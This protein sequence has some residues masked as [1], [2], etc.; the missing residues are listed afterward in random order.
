MIIS[1]RAREILFP[2]QPDSPWK[3]DRPIFDR[4]PLVYQDKDISTGEGLVYIGGPNVKR[5]G[6][7]SLQV[8]VPPIDD[9]TKILI[10]DGVSSWAEGGIQS[11][12][13][14]VDL[15]ALDIDDGQWM[16]GL[17]RVISTET[18]LAAVAPA[19][20]PLSSGGWEDQRFC[21]LA[22]F[23]T[24]FFTVRNLR[25]IR[26]TTDKIDNNVADWITQQPDELV[27]KYQYG[28]K[29]FADEYLNPLTAWKRVDAIDP[30][31]IQIDITNQGIT[32]KADIAPVIQNIYK[33]G[34]SITLEVKAVTKEGYTTDIPYTLAELEDLLSVS[35]EFLAD[36]SFAW[37]WDFDP[38]N[39]TNFQYLPNGETLTLVF[40][41]SILESNDEFWN[42]GRED[43]LLDYIAEQLGWTGDEA[44][45]GFNM[46]P[47]E[48]RRVLLGSFGVHSKDKDYSEWPSPFNESEVPEL[49][50]P[51][52]FV[53]YKDG[54]LGILHDETP[55][56]SFHEFFL[57]A[58]I[59]YD[60]NKKPLF[61]GSA[62]GDFEFKEGD[63]GRWFVTPQS[64]RS[65]DN[66]SLTYDGFDTD[67]STTD[68]PI[69]DFNRGWIACYIVQWKDN[70]N[71][72][73]YQDLFR[74]V[75]NQKGS[76]LPF[77][78]VS[79]ALRLHGYSSCG[80]STPYAQ[81]SFA[82]P[83]CGQGPTRAYVEGTELTEGEPT[84][85][86]GW[87]FLWYR[88]SEIAPGW[89]Y[90]RLTA[91]RDNT[92]ASVEAKRIQTLDPLT[93]LQLDELGFP[94]GVN[95]TDYILED[96]YDE[97]DF[98]T[99]RGERDNLTEG[100]FFKS[101]NLIDYHSEQLHGPFPNVQF[102]FSQVNFDNGLFGEDVEC[103]LDEGTF[104][105]LRNPEIFIDEGRFNPRV[106]SVVWS[107]YI[108]TYPFNYSDWSESFWGSLHFRF[109]ASMENYLTPL[110]VWRSPDMH[111]SDEQTY[112]YENPLIADTNLGAGTQERHLYFLRLPPEYKRDSLE[113]QRAEMVANLLGY[114]GRPRLPTEYDQTD[115]DRY[116]TKLMDEE[117][118]YN[119]SFTGLIYHEDYLESSIVVEDEGGSYELGEVDRSLQVED[120]SPADTR[121]YSPR[122]EIR[123]D[124]TYWQRANST[125]LTGNIPTDERFGSLIQVFG[126]QPVEDY[127]DGVT[128]RVWDNRPDITLARNIRKEQ[129]YGSNYRVAYAYFA[130]DMAVAGDPVFDPSYHTDPL[131]YIK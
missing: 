36:F 119:Q 35:G 111:C 16:F 59:T 88:V 90:Y 6:P 120:F 76:F 103:S 33:A 110:R 57:I 69:A 30:I 101:D 109:N 20:Y 1:D 95:N 127:E 31:E 68:N 26:L 129:Q 21:K 40:E 65:A 86:D 97:E 66:Y 63:N 51:L 8:S 52:N 77:N 91:R 104:A 79:D 48:K 61:L 32:N 15:K 28:A 46:L 116:N 107:R 75:W 58:G 87:M 117:V 17:L 70:L 2:Y 43:A 80:V 82:Y 55:M 3:K 42:D 122:D 92:C 99:L 5:E 113:W 64:G 73:T 13:F 130:A 45:R 67:T 74:G 4:L 98:A 10:Y 38:D 9:A 102:D 121:L 81:L 25:D 14:L 124:G 39:T 53:K 37:S 125:A 54:S 131:G 60:F 22:T 71:W 29:E 23:E 93:V 108:Q 78:F 18:G 56:E 126:G 100:F 118:D 128:K 49:T 11:A 27:T 85:V 114:F 84:S 96:V 105:I 94:R 62:P 112:N 83:H 34:Y 115:N 19:I 12:S 50:V 7:G 47:E 41:V 106:G 44:W 89:D 72:Q 123:W 24:R